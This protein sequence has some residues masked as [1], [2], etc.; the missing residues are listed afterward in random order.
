MARAFRW[1]AVAAAVKAR[2]E[3]LGL[4]QEQAAAASDGAVSTANWSVLERAG[5]TNYRT[6][7][8]RGVCRVLGWSRRSIE[9]VLEGKRPEVEWDGTRSEPEPDIDVRDLERRVVALERWQAQVRRRE[10]TAAAEERARARE[11][12]RSSTREQLEEAAAVRNRRSRTRRQG[13]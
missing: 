2:R 7:T 9:L 13:T 1:E 4:T 12:D 3:E 11:A 6:G 8:L 10:A 5:R